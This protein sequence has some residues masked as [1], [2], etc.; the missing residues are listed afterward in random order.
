MSTLQASGYAQVPPEGGLI[1]NDSVRKFELGTVISDTF[2]NSYRY[3]KAAEALAVG[4][5]VTA[6]VKAAWSATNPI[7]VDGAITANTTA[8]LHVDGG[9]GGGIVELDLHRRGE[10]G[11]G[12]VVPA[13]GD[14]SGGGG[15]DEDLPSGLVGGQELAGVDGVLTEEGA[16]R[17]VGACA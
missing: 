7:I 16:E 2:G 4:Q 15:G 10:V 3:V 14:L 13:E 5:C 11:D 12:R 1:R 9:A 6:T 17:V 8:T